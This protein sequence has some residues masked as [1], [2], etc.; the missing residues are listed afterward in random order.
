MR[1]HTTPF[2]GR[3]LSDYLV[4]KHGAVHTRTTGSHFFY[5]LPSG[6]EVGSVK[7]TQL[8]TAQHARQ[9]AEILGMSYKDFRADIGHPVTET[10]KTRHKPQRVEKRAAT[11]P[12]VA[13][14]ISTIRADLDEAQRSLGG[15]RDA[16]IYER[17]VSDLLPAAAH[18]AKARDSIT[19]RG[20]S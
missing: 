1:Q 13:R 4:K 6:A 3:E 20:A 17:M 12:Q 14:L 9:V 18:V 2:H 15:D 10:G 11:K 8:V 5:R 7:P 16:A 19:K